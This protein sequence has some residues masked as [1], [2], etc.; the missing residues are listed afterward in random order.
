MGLELLFFCYN[1]F[2]F[3]KVSVG[4]DEAL[5]VGVGRSVPVSVGLAPLLIGRR[6][7]SLLALV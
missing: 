3:Y 2:C 6:I 1:L 4:H 5:D 7:G